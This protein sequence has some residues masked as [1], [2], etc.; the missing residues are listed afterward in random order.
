MYEMSGFAEKL[1]IHNFFNSWRNCV[2]Y[3]CME[4]LDLKRNWI[5]RT[6]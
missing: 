5:S 1:N 3:I 2:H 6:A 4:L